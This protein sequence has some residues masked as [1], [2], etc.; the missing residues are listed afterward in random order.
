MNLSQIIP[1]AL[2]FIAAYCAVNWVFANI[3]VRRL[4]D[5]F[6]GSDRD[7]SI[8]ALDRNAFFHGISGIVAIGLAGIIWTL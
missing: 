3:Y 4:K 5:A 8:A 6:P 1:V 7:A 2:S